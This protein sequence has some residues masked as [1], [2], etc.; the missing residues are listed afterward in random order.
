MSLARFV[1]ENNRWLRHR[2]EQV[3]AQPLAQAP[4][5]GHVL[6]DERREDQIERHGA[7]R[8]PVARQHDGAAW[9]ELAHARDHLRQVGSDD[10]RRHD[11]Q[12]GK[13]TA[14]KRS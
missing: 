9:H 5:L 6:K 10:A 3:L 12:E 14:E 8:V 1:F 2:V 13:V 7:G 4:V 11:R